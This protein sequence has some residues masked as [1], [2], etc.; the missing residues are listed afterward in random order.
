MS[1][2]KGSVYRFSSLKTKQKTRV[3]EKNSKL[4]AV[5]TGLSRGVINVDVQSKIEKVH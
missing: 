3:L 4:R 5:S 1:F 2:G